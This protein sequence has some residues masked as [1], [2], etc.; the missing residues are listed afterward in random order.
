MIRLFTAL[1]IPQKIRQRLSL[2]GGG[3]PGARWVVTDAMHITLRFIGE[4]DRP[5][6]RDIDSALSDLQGPPISLRLA[7]IDQFG[8]KKKPRSLWMGVV[9]GAEL[10]DLQ[11]RMETKL[12]RIGLKPDGRNFTPHVTL[13]RLKNSPIDRVAAFMAN[14]NLI[15]TENFTVDHFTL[16][17][18]HPAPE[19]SLYIEEESYP[20]TLPARV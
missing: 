16:F 3:I 18:S 5:M 7:G 9:A 10:F 19:G 11:K 17:S 12:T 8:D 2:M 14:N 15:T 13:A 4:V 6:A 20:L 1:E